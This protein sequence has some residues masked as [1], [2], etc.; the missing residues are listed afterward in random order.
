MKRREL[1]SRTLLAS[2]GGAGLFSQLVQLG[3]ARAAAL[4]STSIARGDD[5]KAL[6]CVFLNGGNDNV[7]TVIP[8]DA[9]THA[10]YHAVRPNLSLPLANLAGATHRHP[11]T[12]QTGGRPDALL[13]AMPEIADLFNSGRGALIAYVGTLI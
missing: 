1:L 11:L 6:V 2:L 7:N 4:D 8:R 13:P 10:L 5:Y 12:P 9:A 3:L